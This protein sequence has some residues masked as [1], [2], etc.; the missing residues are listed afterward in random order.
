MTTTLRN[1]FLSPGARRFGFRFSLDYLRIST[2]VARHWGHTGPGEMRLLGNRV[3]YPNQSHAVFLLHELFV[4]LAYG[5]DVTSAAPRIVDCGANIGMSILFFKLWA[6]DA[7]IVAIEPD[8]AAFRYLQDL[9]TLNGLRNV[10]LI[11]AAI[12]R[13]RGFA[14]FYTT[15]GD[16]ASIAS[17]LQ[18]GWGGA[19]QTTV[20]TLPL[21]DLIDAPI[22]FLKL[23]IEGSEYEAIDDMESSG[24]LSSI[25]AM[26]VEC[27]DLTADDGPRL[28]LLKQLEHAGF[29]VS[30]ISQDGR[31]TVLR[32]ARA[33]GAPR[34]VS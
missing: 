6:P 5:F 11:N 33:N 29:G 17:S 21:S 12:A 1:A 19:G 27:H 28:R 30:T 20:R 13:Q 23:D 10:E 34:G 32:A 14:A 25:H 26:A 16:A 3:Q 31:V 22:D 7:T 9:V 8:V 24:R 15:S 2:R 4:N 18:S